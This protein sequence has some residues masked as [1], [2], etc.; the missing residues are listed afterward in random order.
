MGHSSGSATQRDGGDQ[1]VSIILDSRAFRQTCHSN[2]PC[3]IG[4][5][6]KPSMLIDAIT[7]ETTTRWVLDGIQ[8][9]V[10]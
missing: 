2:V 8:S 9:N 3:S 6:L 10:R 4:F 5:K 7:L 1:G